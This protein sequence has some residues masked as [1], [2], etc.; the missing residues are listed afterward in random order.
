VLVRLT[1]SS[2]NYFVLGSKRSVMRH[3]PISICPRGTA[4]SRKYVY[5]RCVCTIVF[6]DFVI[7]LYLPELAVGTKGV[8]QAALVEPWA[9][10]LTWYTRPQ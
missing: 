9:G 3:T 10:S 7:V 8:L 6:Y 1:E 4:L 5:L 2:G